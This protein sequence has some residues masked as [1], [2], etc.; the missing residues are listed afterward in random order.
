MKGAEVRCEIVFV[1]SDSL[2]LG[3]ADVVRLA[4]DG[5][6]AARTAVGLISAAE[7]APSPTPNLNDFAL[8]LADRLH[9]LKVQLESPGDQRSDPP[10]E[11][12]PKHLGARD[13]E[14]IDRLMNILCKNYQ[15][16]AFGRN[17]MSAGL[18]VSGR[19]LQRKLKIILNTNPSDLLRDYRLQQAEIKLR[20]GY[21]VK[22]VSERCGFGSTAHFSQCFKA[23]Y[24]LPPKRYQTKHRNRSTARGLS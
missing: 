1:I 18:G 20:D 12:T 6:S 7:D 5:A 3:A 11:L 4:R 19:H 21:Q 16:R 17:D 13:Q 8:M 10:N 9:Q 22:Q 14:F 2:A 24:G 15:I 23:K